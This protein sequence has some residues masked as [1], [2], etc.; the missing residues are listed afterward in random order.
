MSPRCISF[1]MPGVTET[2]VKSALPP[3]TAVLMLGMVCSGRI[4]IDVE[5]EAVLLGDD[6][7]DDIDGRRALVP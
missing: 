4:W 2:E 1:S 5:V 6:A 7:A 3:A